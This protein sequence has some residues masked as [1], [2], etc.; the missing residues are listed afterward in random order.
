MRNGRED[1]NRSGT[2][3]KNAVCIWCHDVISVSPLCSAFHYYNE[4][5]EV[6]YFI[7]KVYLVQFQRLQVQTAWCRPLAASYHGGII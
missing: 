7:K 2:I 1:E 6:S 4:I 5:P 3:C